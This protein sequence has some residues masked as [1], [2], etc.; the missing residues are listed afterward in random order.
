M[1]KDLQ[2]IL[3]SK[4]QIAQR[5]KEIGEQLNKDYAGKV[6]VVIGVLNGSVVFYSDLVREMTGHI[7][8]SFITL[9]S[10]GDGTE[11][12]GKVKVVTDLKVDIYD[13]DVII[14]EDIVDSGITLKNLVALLKERSPKSVK[15]VALLDK[16]K[17]RKVPFE[18][19]YYGFKI[20]NEFV[21]GYGL[22]YAQRYR[23]LPEIGVVDPK[24]I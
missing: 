16:F 3:F 9:S 18:V 4:E 13:R 21:V 20:E 22:D 2:K 19:D 23:N 6:P 1:Y 10:Y 5:V 14:V 11:T 24:R 17:N 8:M 7:T 12:S 15:V